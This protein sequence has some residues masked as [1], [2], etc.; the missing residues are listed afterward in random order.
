MITTQ[1]TFAARLRRQHGISLVTLFRVS[2][3]GLD[4]SDSPFAAEIKGNFIK[5]GPVSVGFQFC[6]IPFWVLQY[7][8]PGDSNS[9]IDCGARC[10]KHPETKNMCEAYKSIVSSQQPVS[11]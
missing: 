10:M 5:M 7:K 4:C 11:L 6:A 2:L 9:S 1:G 3:A 8:L